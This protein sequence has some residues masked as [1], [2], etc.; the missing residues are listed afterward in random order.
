M[1]SADLPT[2]PTVDDMEL[3]V[4]EEPVK[5]EE[6]PI[7]HDQPLEVEEQQQQHEQQQQEVVQEQHEPHPEL[8]Q[9]EVT[10]DNDNNL[11]PSLDL[12]S[13]ARQDAGTRVILKQLM[14]RRLHLCR[15]CRI[16]HG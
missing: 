7:H 10:T 2:I 9:E 16:K 1:S 6:E 3:A 14:H 5:L 11:P 8:P 13:R 12:Q 15:Q 4:P